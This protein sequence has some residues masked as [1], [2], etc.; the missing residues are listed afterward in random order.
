MD[1]PALRNSVVCVRRSRFGVLA[2][3]FVAATALT[4]AGCGGDDEDSATVDW[5]NGVCGA[6]TTWKDSV[7]SATDEL[8]TGTGDNRVE[9][10][11]NDMEDATRTL[12]D[13]LDGLDA[14]QTDAGRQAE[15]AIDALAQQLD[16]SIQAVKNA[17]DAAEGKGL[18]E[19]LAAVSAISGT[20]ASMSAAV[21]QAL[22]QLQEA[23]GLEEIKS[24]F[25]DADSCGDLR[26]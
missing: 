19:Q 10:A 7:V 2:A 20:L 23:D 4:A 11:V 3:A 5:A 1:A 17:G 26:R 9:A 6:V 25:D 21:S 12:A 16:T 24:A 15:A 8:K 14:P 18:T 22:D 13:D